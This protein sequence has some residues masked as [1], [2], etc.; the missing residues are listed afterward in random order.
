[1]TFDLL[2]PKELAAHSGW[3]ERR[4]RN[5]ISANQLRHMRVG[6][7]ILSPKDAVDEYIRNHM[8]EPDPTPPANSR[9]A[10]SQSRQPEPLIAGN[11]SVKQARQM[12][13]KITQART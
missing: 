3:T 2:S 13:K 4:I 6:A 11:D 1:M 10:V 5:L 9:K 8:I 12:I 7:S